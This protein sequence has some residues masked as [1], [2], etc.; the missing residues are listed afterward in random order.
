MYEYTIHKDGNK[1]FRY[2]IYAN[3]SWLCGGNVHSQRD[4]IRCAKR[5]VDQLN[6]SVHDSQRQRMATA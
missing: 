1:N 6:R 2:E 3:K 4:A 5:E